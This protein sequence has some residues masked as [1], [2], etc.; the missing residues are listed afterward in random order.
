M[1][2][3]EIFEAKK[4]LR[5]KMKD[6][7]FRIPEEER[8]RQNKMLTEMILGTEMYANARYILSYISFG[9]E[10]DTKE[11]IKKA[12]RDT[13]RV[14]VPKV[15]QLLKKDHLQQETE[16]KEP[17]KDIFF[18]EI[19]DLSG[20]KMS[21]MGVPEPPADPSKKFPYELHLSLDRAEECLLFV[22]GLAFDS[23][24]HRIGYGSGYYD[25]FLNRF[26]KKMAVGLAYS[27]Q[28]IESVP[29]TD[30]DEALDLVVSPSGAF[31]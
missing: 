1:T 2:Q 8:A 10:V 13:K 16:A 19:E 15:Q 29:V 23:S 31:Y 14:Y 9:T 28:I 4:E 7:R 25:R 18:Y 24:L 26:R 20:L 21:S 22:P 11:L 6:I 12:I 27:E 5:S 3:E 30:H 17:E